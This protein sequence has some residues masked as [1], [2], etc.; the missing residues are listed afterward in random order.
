MPDGMTFASLKTAKP[1]WSGQQFMEMRQSV[2]R[3]M[4]TLR[5]DRSPYFAVWRELSQFVM[6]QRGRFVMPPSP[7]DTLKGL[8]KQQQIIDRTATKAVKAMGA[9]LMAGITSPARDW[10]RL[11]TMRDELNDDHAV[12]GWLSEVDKRLR[13][14]LAAG[15]F[16][17][18]MASLYEELG[19]FGTGVM[20]C[21]PDFENVMQ[22]TTLTA[23][24]YMLVNGKDGRPNTLYREMV[25]SVQAVVEEFGI[26]NCSEMVRDLH[27]AQQYSRE[28]NVVHAIYPNCDLKK[29]RNDW[30]GM[31]YLSIRYEYGYAVEQLLSCAGFHE[32]PAVAPRWDVVANDT[33]GHGPGEEALPD[34]KMLQILRRR[35]AE[36]IDKMI[37]PPMMGP[38][39]LKNSLVQLIPGGMNYVDMT[40]GPQSMRPVL[41]I[42]PNGIQPLA[43]MVMQTQQT[44]QGAFFGD[45]IAQFSQGDTPDMTAREVD[46]RHEEK[47]L[48]LGPMLERFHSEALTPVLDIVFNRMARTGLLPMPIPPKL[49]GMHLEPTFISLLAQAQKAVGTQAIE[50]LFAFAGRLV[51]VV[52]DVMDNLDADAAVDAYAG[53]IGT[54]AQIVRDPAKVAAMRAGRAQ[55]EQ[56]AQAAQQG[57][58]AV[59][60]A[61]TMSQTPIGNGQSALQA[62]LPQQ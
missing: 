51:A 16:Y 20:L 2:D 28:V 34:V 27:E 53:M 31:E 38:A 24:E 9:F 50:A 7:N 25:M 44:I 33:Y 43:E 23:G 32:F 58:A 1:Q 41:E 4:T 17:N 21:L 12:K 15:T 42:P 52:P 8:P 49:H 46:E 36:A 5:S 40:G 3:A 11:G 60:A 29:G 62:A 37:K 48:L 35:Q 18:A 55:Q 47:V 59:Q 19:T 22:F 13:T 61:Q 26:D 30:Q 10:F 39:S 6:P 14:V 54:D 57:M 56:Q 45:L